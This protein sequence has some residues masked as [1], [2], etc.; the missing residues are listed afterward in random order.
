MKKNILIRLLV[1]ALALCAMGG[2]GG[3]YF[4]HKRVATLESRLTELEKEELRSAV[5]KS[6]SEQMSVIASQQKDIAEEKREEALKEKQRA[7]EAF[8]RSEEERRKALE[9]EH[10]AKLEKEKADM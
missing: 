1:G 5:D 7:D 6:V 3:W 2:I 4:E 8:Q 9:A 10:E